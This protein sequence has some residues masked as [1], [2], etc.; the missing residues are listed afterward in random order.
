MGKEANQK[1]ALLDR[2]GLAIS[3]LC[4]AHCVISIVL[5][6][7]L[8]F[9][10]QFLLAPEIHEF[11]LIAAVMV[12][13]LAIG[14]GALN[15]RRPAPIIAALIG[16]SFMA[17]ALSMPHDYREMLMTIV[18]VGFVAFAHVLNMRVGLHQPR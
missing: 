6:T 8:G 18:G 3:S 10:S 13:I 2:L 16:L 1:R 9:A 17:G 4:L 12:V 14:W 5:V 15:H 11:G 7:G